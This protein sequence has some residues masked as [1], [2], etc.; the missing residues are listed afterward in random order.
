MINQVKEFSEVHIADQFEP[1]VPW[2]FISDQGWKGGDDIENHEWFRIC[3][4]NIFERILPFNI[5][6]ESCDE[7]QQNIE[8]ESDVKQELPSMSLL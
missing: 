6:L 3:L 8:S 2:V 1:V 4:S 7:I 5:H